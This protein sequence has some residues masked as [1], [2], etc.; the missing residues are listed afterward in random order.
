[1]VFLWFFLFFAGGC[2]GSVVFICIDQLQGE[3][4]REREREVSVMTIITED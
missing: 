2:E 4:E 3:G 1:M